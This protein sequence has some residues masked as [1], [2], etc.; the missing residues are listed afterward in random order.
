MGGDKPTDSLGGQYA[1]FTG[2][3]PSGG[4]GLFGLDQSIW[5][6]FGKGVG[7]GVQ[8]YGQGVASGGRSQIPQ[9]SQ[10]APIEGGSQPVSLIPT[11]GATGNEIL[12]A[13][14]RLGVL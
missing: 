11:S 8:A 10:D 9:F 6:G 5:S 4:S 12:E 13:L 14:Q 7:S 3:T 2:G 1:S